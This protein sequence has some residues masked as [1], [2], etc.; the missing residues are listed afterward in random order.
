MDQYQ[1]LSSKEA[2]KRF[3]EQGPNELEAEKET[4]TFRQILAALQEPMLLLLAGT[5]TLYFFLG[6]TG[7]A[8]VMLVFVAFVSGISVSQELKTQ[9]TIAQL[10]ELSAPDVEVIRDGQR[11]RIPTRD[12][13]VG[14]LFILYEG[15]R[16][17]A[18][19]EL[20]EASDLL[21]DES[22]LTG[23]AEAVEKDPTFETKED[24]WQ[25]N[26]CYAGTFVIR[27]SAIAQVTEIGS[28][29]EY[30]KIGVAL[31]E[32]KL[33]PTPLE[34]QTRQLV[35]RMAL[36]GLV[37]CF[38]VIGIVY[39]RGSN[40]SESLIA[41]LTLAMAMIPEEFP[42]VLTV[43]LAL[44]ASRLARKEA[45]AR[46]IPAVETLG[47]VTVLCVDKTGTLTK[48]E[49]TVRGSSWET[50]EEDLIRTS[51]LASE[52]VPYDP[53]E[54]AFFSFAKTKGFDPKTFQQEGELVHEYAFSRE[55]KMM[56]HIWK[57]GEEHLLAVKGSP[58][59]VLP[60]CANGEALASQVEKYAKEGRRVLAF[61][62]ATAG[63]PF[64]ELEDYSL[65][66]VG[67]LA[68]AD[69]PREGVREAIATCQRA[70]IRLKMITGDYGP[71]AE[72]IA[73]EVGILDHHQVLTG[74]EMDELTQEELE[75]RVEAV[76]V[77]ARVRPEHKLRIVRALRARGQVVGM[78][79]DGVNDAPALKEADIG[80]AMGGRGSSVA[81][82]AADLVLLDDDFSTIE[83]SVADGRRI[84]DNIRKAMSYILVVH[85][86]IAL[87][88]LFAPLFGLPLLLLPIHV[89]LLELIIDPTCSIVFEAQG[90]EEDLMTR[91]PRDRDEPIIKGEML[92][93]LA[94]LGIALLVVAFV[95]Y[96]QMLLEGY[97]LEIARSFALSTML[98]GNIFLVASMESNIA[99]FYRPEPNPTR[100]WVNTFTLGSLLLLLYLPFAQRLFQTGPLSFTQLAGAAGLAAVAVFW[101][102][103]GKWQRRRQL[104]KEKGE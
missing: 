87:L 39:F 47:A 73:H 58:E 37:L 5:A 23:E 56:G 81:R 10:R 98:F 86:P 88:A 69:P 4:S 30:G 41:G 59:T 35:Q 8:L 19:G 18:D 94:L 34:I 61:A 83:R 74:E 49:M 31:E 43:F 60:R 51:I 57:L 85:F 82:E 53:M 50:T 64:G 68:L 90:A 26:R 22:L 24:Y 65:E 102:E 70:G 78:T 62:K 17:A 93:E 6:Q 40:F 80:I 27:G 104:R 25:G 103:I 28:R 89:V 14:D 32:T 76:N 92:W 96:R 63:E 97:P 33:R 84:F 77:F 67:L 55:T 9:R 15:E 100:F 3:L 75:D 1:G 11:K 7:D 38:S 66:A 2:K 79:G 91:P 54:E 36:V 72:A 101:R 13:V 95:P 12:L 45:L 21:I 16:V 52:L 71:T 44:G 20:L 99:P 46:R 29:T 48:N 42:V